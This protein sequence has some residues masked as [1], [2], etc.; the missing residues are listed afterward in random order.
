M[1]RKRDIEELKKLVKQVEEMLGRVAPNVARDVAEDM[2][3][4]MRG[5]VAV[6]KPPKRKPKPVL[7]VEDDDEAGYDYDEYDEET[8][9]EVP[10]TSPTNAEDTSTQAQTWVAVP[11]V[12]EDQEERSQSERPAQDS[13]DSDE[14]DLM[15]MQSI[16]WMAV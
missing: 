7:Q 1:H 8:R 6:P 9:R 15:V 13:D 11:P 3:R 10:G 12:L 16:S 4:A 14:V 2:E 5:I